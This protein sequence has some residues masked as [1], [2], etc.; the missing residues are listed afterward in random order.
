[1][2]GVPPIVNSGVVFVQDLVNHHALEAFTGELLW[3]DEALG[4]SSNATLVSDGELF[5][6]PLRLQRC[7]QRRRGPSA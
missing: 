3:S 6:F 4:G 2:N 5:T 1:M 7:F